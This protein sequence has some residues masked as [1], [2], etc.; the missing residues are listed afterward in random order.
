MRFGGIAAARSSRQHGERT[1]PE[2]KLHPG[3]FRYRC[4]PYA[5]PGYFLAGDAANFVTTSTLLDGVMHWE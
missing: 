4:I 5:G 3:G 2:K 1:F